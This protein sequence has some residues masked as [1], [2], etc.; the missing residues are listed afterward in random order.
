MADVHGV[1][2]RGLVRRGEGLGVEGGPVQ[3]REEGVG[4]D[5]VRPAEEVAWGGRGVCV[6]VLLDGRA[7]GV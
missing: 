1:A 7:V 5:V 2:D 6:G 4:L 3:G